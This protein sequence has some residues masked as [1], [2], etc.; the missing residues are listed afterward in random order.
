MQCE[1]NLDNIFLHF[2]K[3]QSKSSRS[4]RLSKKAEHARKIRSEE[5]RRTKSKRQ[6][7]DAENHRPARD[8]NSTMEIYLEYETLNYLIR[9]PSNNIELCLAYY[10]RGRKYLYDKQFAWALQD[11][12]KANKL[13]HDKK[14]L[15]FPF[16]NVCDQITKAE[17]LIKD[18][19]V[20]SEYSDDEE[21]DLKLDEIVMAKRKE[22]LQ[23]LGKKEPIPVSMFDELLKAVNTIRIQANQAYKD[24]DMKRALH[25]YKYVR[26]RRA[27]S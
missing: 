22:I 8:N 19:P 6:A 14:L 16:K 1:T 5:D 18:L 11:F 20:T 12:K 26:G 13:D 25:L 10:D 15:N 24:R 3:Q 2:R 23:P 21:E 17:N 4:K 7:T 9:H 27:R